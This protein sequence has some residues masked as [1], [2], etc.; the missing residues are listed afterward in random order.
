ME[1]DLCP[2]LPTYAGQGSE[3]GQETQELA[4]EPTPSWTLWAPPFCPRH[5]FVL[6]WEARSQGTVLWG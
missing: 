1:T 6:S 2:R 4:E 3:G 5:P